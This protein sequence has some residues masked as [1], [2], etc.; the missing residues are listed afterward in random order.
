[1]ALFFFQNTVYPTYRKEASNNAYPT[2]SWGFFFSFAGFE[3]KREEEEDPELQEF[4]SELQEFH[5]QHAK[6]ISRNAWIFH[7]DLDTCHSKRSHFTVSSCAWGDTLQGHS[8]SGRRGYFPSLQRDLICT[9]T[10]PAQT[11]I[12]LFSQPGQLRTQASLLSYSTVRHQIHDDVQGGLLWAK[13]VETLQKAEG[14]RSWRGR[15]CY[16]PKT[17]RESQV[18]SRDLEAG[19]RKAARS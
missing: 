15:W 11:A 1:M 2:H 17:P 10:A 13:A 16:I 19:S 5:S 18:F 3:E 8:A 4:H 14:R 9:W 12:R 7:D 6:A